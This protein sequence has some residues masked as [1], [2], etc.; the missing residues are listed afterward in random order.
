PYKKSSNSFGFCS[1]RLLIPLESAVT[2]KPIPI[3]PSNVA[4]AFLIRYRFNV[5]PWLQFTLSS[6]GPGM[7]DLLRSGRRLQPCN[8]EQH[9]QRGVGAGEIYI[10]DVYAMLRV[11]NESRNKVTKF[12]KD[13]DEHQRAESHWIRSNHKKHKLPR[14]CHSRESVIKQRMGDRRRILNPD[15]VKNE[16]QRRDDDNSPNAGNREKVFRE[17]HSATPATK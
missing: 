4:A 7:F 16:I 17:F 5:A 13:A 3:P 9:R 14:Q 10:C 2:E 11:E 12:F 15:H 6:E 1:Y 8:Q